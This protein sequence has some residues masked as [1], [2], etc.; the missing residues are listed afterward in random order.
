MVKGCVRKDTLGSSIYHKFMY[1]CRC[2]CVNMCVYIYRVY[3]YTVYTINYD[4][5]MYKLYIRVQIYN[6]MCVYT[7]MF[8]EGG[9]GGSGVTAKAAP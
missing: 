8:L 5:N 1:N 7:Y 2:V 6:S 4:N 9:L 3:I